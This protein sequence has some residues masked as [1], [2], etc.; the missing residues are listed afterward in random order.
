MGAGHHILR[1]VS[2]ALF[3]RIT[4]MWHKVLYILWNG[5]SEPAPNCCR[6]KRKWFFIRK[7][8][9]TVR[10]VSFLGFQ[11]R[12]WRRYRTRRQWWS[13]GGV[14][15]HE[16]NRIDLSL[17]DESKLHLHKTSTKS[18]VL[19]EWK[20][21]ELGKFY[22]GRYNITFCY[23]CASVDGIRGTSLWV[24]MVLRW[25]AVH[26]LYILLPTGPNWNNCRVFFVLLLSIKDIYQ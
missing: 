25:L 24:C 9:W 26:S 17:S 3:S 22:V 7:T 18:T 12:Y 15:C 4:T 8:C 21:L 19:N 11:S 20:E 1:N 16:Q 23:F 13:W 14:V 10:K 2:P 6:W 5:G